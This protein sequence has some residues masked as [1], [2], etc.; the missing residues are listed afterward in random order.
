LP[1]YSFASVSTL[2][3]LP[4]NRDNETMVMSWSV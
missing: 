1:A 3:Q 2:S 4:V